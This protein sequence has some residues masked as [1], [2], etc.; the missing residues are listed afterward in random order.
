MA[1]ME[2]D[3]LNYDIISEDIGEDEKGCYS[4]ERVY[5]KEYWNCHPETCTHFG[6]VRYVDY[7]RKIYK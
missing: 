3:W 4:I 6:T 7:E 5:G 2:L 1:M